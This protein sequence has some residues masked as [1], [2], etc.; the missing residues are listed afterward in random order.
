VHRVFTLFFLIVLFFLWVV[1]IYVFICLV[2]LLDGFSS[3]IFIYMVS[4][5]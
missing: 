4:F 2:L 5:F 3:S 1:S